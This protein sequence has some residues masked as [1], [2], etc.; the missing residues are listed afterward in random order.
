MNSI[1]YEQSELE[2]EEKTVLFHQLFG[3][4]L[5]IKKEFIDPSRLSRKEKESDL[6]PRMRSSEMRKELLQL[7]P[8]PGGL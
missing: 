7:I 8:T 6:D 1:T 4:L 2:F 5:A 3:Y